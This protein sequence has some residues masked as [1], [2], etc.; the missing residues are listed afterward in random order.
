MFEKNLT[1]TC[2]KIMIVV[3]HIVNNNSYALYVLLTIVQIHCC[4]IDFCLSSMLLFTKLSP[5]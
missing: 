1:S 4:N 3:I 2:S 5:I